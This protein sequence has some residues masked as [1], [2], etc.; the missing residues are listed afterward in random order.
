MW[1]IISQR[2]IFFQDLKGNDIRRAG[3]IPNQ[4]SDQ[5]VHGEYNNHSFLRSWVNSGQSGIRKW[6]V[7]S[8]ILKSKT[9]DKGTSGYLSN[10]TIPDVIAEDLVRKGRKWRPGWTIGNMAQELQKT[11]EKEEVMGACEHSVKWN[12]KR[13]L[14]VVVSGFGSFGDRFWTSWWVVTTKQV[15][16]VEHGMTVTPETIAYTCPSCT[17]WRS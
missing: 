1:Y 13:E 4:R 15:C 16:V 9:A 2:I 17:L 11:N 3:Q 12:E 14:V 10:C 7:C 6:C 8:K 5:E